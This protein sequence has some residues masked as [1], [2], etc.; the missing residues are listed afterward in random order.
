[1]T[2]A[3][4][5]P[6][7]PLFAA[8]RM[9][10]HAACIWLGCSGSTELEYRSRGVTERVADRLAVKAGL[11]P[12]VVWPEMAEHTM[13]QIQR[14]CDHCEELFFPARTDQRFC[15]PLCRKRWHGRRSQAKYQRSERGREYTNERRRRFYQENAEYE[16]ARERRRYHAKREIPSPYVPVS[17]S[18]NSDGGS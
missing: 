8:M 4:R 18:T 15:T 16:K 1:M 6:L 3:R 9:S 5:Y 10:P 17:L 14:R 12:Y 11:H 2:Q 7:D 13:T